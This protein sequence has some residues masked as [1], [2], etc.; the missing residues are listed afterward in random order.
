MH[1]YEKRSYKKVA[2]YFMVTPQGVSKMI[3]SIEEELGE[4]LFVKEKNRLIATRAAEELY[5]HASRILDEFTSIENANS[6]KRKKVTIY[7]IDSVFD[8]YLKEFLS[9]FLH[10]Y[11]NI[12]LNVIETTHENAI[13]HLQKRDCDFV[14]L[15]EP[16][17]SPQFVCDFLFESP[18]VFV[19]NKDN[20]LSQ[21]DT[22]V[23]GDLDGVRMAGR[24]FE[25]SM[26]DRYF[27]I[28]GRQGVFPVTVFESNDAGLLME[29]VDR[30]IAIASV[31]ERVAQAYLKDNM[32]ILKLDDA[33]IND[34][35]CI[36]HYEKM[37]REAVVFLQEL[38]EWVREDR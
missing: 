36:M 29:L 20:P 19:V 5:P 21:K 33:S 23:P 34:R 3:R 22:L 27:K 25:Y 24:G 38:K 2:E 30:D 28:L 16:V 14:V 8:R 17:E 7:S 37:P 35:I 9:A 26:Y 1:A 15:Q 4:K 12:S 32:K 11:S 18:F 10:K 31:N 6:R 13:L